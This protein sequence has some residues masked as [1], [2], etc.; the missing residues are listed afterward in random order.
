MYFK[1]VYKFGDIKSTRETP[2]VSIFGFEWLIWILSYVLR[3][4]MMQIDF[5]KIIHVFK[6]LK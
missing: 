2:V 6:N 3:W 5:Q 4:S 1:S